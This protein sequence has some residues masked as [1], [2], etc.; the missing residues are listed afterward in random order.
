[1]PC[2]VAR[3]Q[4]GGFRR[5]GH[6]GAVLRH[7]RR[8][9][10]RAPRGR[11]CS[12]SATWAKLRS[13]GPEAAGLADYVTTNDAA[14]A[15]TRPGAIFR[16]ALSSMADSWTTSWCTRWPT[17][18]ISFASTLPTR[19][20]I[21]STSAARNRFGATVEFASDRYAQIARSRARRRCATLAEA[22]RHGSRRHPL[23]LFRRR[24]GFGRPGA[25]RPHRLHRRGRV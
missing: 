6:A 22:H 4:N 21:S 12:M 2:I 10:C 11:R 1:M 18:T 8:A 14:Q 20:R 24:R 5:L 15:E 13:A 23:L 19:K 16:P 17:T 25:H 3:L 9:P 7:P